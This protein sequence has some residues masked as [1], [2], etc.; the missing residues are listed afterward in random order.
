VVLNLK[1]PKRSVA[2]V[3]YAKQKL[4]EVSFA[5]N[6]KRKRRKRLRKRKP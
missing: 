6:L 2:F 1:V 4:G 5:K 3:V